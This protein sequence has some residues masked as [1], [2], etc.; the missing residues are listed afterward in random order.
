VRKNFL[1]AALILVAGAVLGWLGKGMA[2]PNDPAPLPGTEGDPLVS[3][4]YVDLKTAVNV[5][6][7]SPGK[8]LIGF[9]GTEIILRSGT[10]RAVD[11]NLGGLCD[12]TAGTDLRSGEEIPRNHLLIVPRDDGRGISATSHAIVMVRGKYTL[13]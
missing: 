9:S 11:S 10:A 4:S 2:S 7:L 12:V 5:V 13:K 6:E 1:H 8:S 3:R